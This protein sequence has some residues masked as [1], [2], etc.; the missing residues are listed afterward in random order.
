MSEPEAR[1]EPG[2]PYGIVAIAASAGGIIALG[3]VFSGLPTGFPVPVLV[4][5]HLDPRHKTIIADVL[6]RRANMPV[7]LAQEGDHAEAGTRREPSSKE[8]C[9]AW[10]RA[11]WCLT[12]T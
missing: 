10:P 9:R 11:W 3:H 8:F 6:G 1:A 5:Q 7:V 12:R 4:V 2:E